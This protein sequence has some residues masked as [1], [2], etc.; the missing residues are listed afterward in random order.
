VLKQAQ[1]RAAQKFKCLIEE[2]EAEG[3]DMT[4]HVIDASALEASLFGPEGSRSIID[5]VGGTAAAGA[6]SS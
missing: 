5:V 2:L 4:A 3:E 6:G 1:G